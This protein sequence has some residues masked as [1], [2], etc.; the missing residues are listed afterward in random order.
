M[1]EA[2]LRLWFGFWIWAIY[3][4][5][6]RRPLNRL[7][8]WI[9]REGAAPTRQLAD[10]KT[11]NDV[12]QRLMDFE[13]RRDET[14]IGG[15]AVPLDYVSDPMVV[16]ARLHNRAVRDGDCDDAHHYAAVQLSRM[17]GVSKALHVTI[18]YP[19]GGHMACVYEFENSWY[20]MNYDRVH[21]L[22]DGPQ[23]AEA[24]LMRW[25][26]HE[27][28]EPRWFVFETPQLERTQP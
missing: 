5:R 22:P 27:G 9:N 1:K 26:G 13:W 11:P 3:A 16:E 19:G 8:R 18:G 25:A 7:Q 20:L 17:K 12:R 23:Q 15:L 6:L 14:R 24:I 2:F 28:K 21:A 4:G 10:L